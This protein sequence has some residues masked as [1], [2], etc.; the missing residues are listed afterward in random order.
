MD[1]LN[2]Y[3]GVVDY[4]VGSIVYGSFVFLVFA[5]ISVIGWRMGERLWPTIFAILSLLGALLIVL[6]VL[7]PDYIPITHEVTLRP[8]GV[9]DARKYDIIEQRGA[10][11]VIEE[12]EVSAE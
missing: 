1:V 10:I 12:R 8:G 2:T 4:S 7:K 5:G 3:G 9:I 6:S 11:F